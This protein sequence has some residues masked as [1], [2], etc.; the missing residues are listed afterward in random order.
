M[1]VLKAEHKTFTRSKN[2]CVCTSCLFALSYV[3]SQRELDIMLYHFLLLFEFYYAEAFWEI[4]HFCWTCWCIAKVHRAKKKG[5]LDL[6]LIAKPV[7]D[8]LVHPALGVAC[9][10]DFQSPSHNS[11]K[12]IV[13]CFSWLLFLA[14]LL[15]CLVEHMGP[16]LYFWCIVSP[17]YPLGLSSWKSFWL[18]PG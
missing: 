14:I 8:C 3:P 18:V 17:H 11:M 15:L 9:V 4:S 10:G 16:Y 1:Y 5:W 7:R 2:N 6:V 13:M 12:E